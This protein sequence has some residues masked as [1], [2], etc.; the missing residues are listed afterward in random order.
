MID[1]S[2]FST[3]DSSV[4]QVLLIED[5]PGYADLLREIL[6]RE[7]E[8]LFALEWVD[9]LQSGLRRLAQGG[10]DAV[11]LDLSLPDSQGFDTFV[12]ACAQASQVPIV[13]LTAIDNETVAIKA[14]QEGAQD[15]LV[16]GQVGNRMLSRVIRYAMERH[17]LLAELGYHTRELQASEARFRSIIEKNADGIVVVD[18]DGIMRFVNPAAESLLDRKA[19]ELLGEWFGFPVAGGETMEIEVFRRS[20]KAAIAEMRVVE[21]VWEGEITYLA[22][23]RDITD[24]K[25]MLAELEKTRQQQLQVKNQFLSHVSHE[26]R[27]P[28]TA[29]YQFVTNLLDG[30]AGDLK[31]EQREHLEIA[32]RNVNQLRAMIADLLEVTRAETGKLTV[33]PQCTSVA[34]LVSETLCTLRTTASAKAIVLSAGIPRDLPP[35][36]ADPDRV[37]Q[38]LINLIDNGIKF[39]PENGAVSIRAYLFDEDPN[40]VCVA[41]ADTGCGID[42]E[43]SQMIFERLYQAADTIDG[44][45][46]G[47]GLGLYICRELVSRHGGRIWVESQVGHGSTFFFTLPTFSRSRSD[48]AQEG[49]QRIGGDSKCWPQAGDYFTMVDT[50]PKGGQQAVRTTRQKEV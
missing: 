32:L 37:R 41:V 33:K 47:L 50:P 16:K 4:V 8:P 49:W 17:R 31:P 27:S 1:N 38:I 45:R 34:E 15:Y 36:Y 39:T 20:G 26:L 19:G 22:S 42:R 44:S 6:L 23:L 46:K 29:I 2:P 11:L 28:L 25:Q 21:M 43:S 18:R 48:L 7:K 9:R 12:Q 3:L 35:V 14:V 40:F 13:V 24:R 30:L 10:I 5:D